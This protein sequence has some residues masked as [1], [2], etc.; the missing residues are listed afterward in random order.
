MRTELTGIVSL[1]IQ[2]SVCSCATSSCR[3]R[4]SYLQKI[5]EI[6]PLPAFYFLLSNGSLEL[7]PV[8]ISLCP[9]SA[10]GCRGDLSWGH[11]QAPSP[12]ML[13]QA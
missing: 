2:P 6:I 9:G 12:A 3:A 1:K 5:R 10:G 7:L 4:P 8:R 11:C 13:F